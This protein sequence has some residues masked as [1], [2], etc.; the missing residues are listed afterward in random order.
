[1]NDN[2][3]SWIAW[4]N[5]R[6]AKVLLLTLIECIMEGDDNQSLRP[7]VQGWRANALRALHADNWRAP[8]DSYIEVWADARLSPERDK[9]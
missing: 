6:D 3:H 4:V 1:M 5:D 2:D 7:V 8:V 9:T